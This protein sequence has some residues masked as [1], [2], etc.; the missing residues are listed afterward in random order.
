MKEILSYKYILPLLI[1]FF[2]L[3]FFSS[4]LISNEIVGFLLFGFV[5]LR[6]VYIS[7][8]QIPIKEIFLLILIIQYFIAP[9]VV[10]NK[11]DND[12]GDFGY[13]M[14]IYKEEYF[15]FIIGTIISVLIGL[16][17]PLSRSKIESSKL[18]NRLASAKDNFK[19]GLILLIIGF[20][21]HLINP[22]LPSSLAFLGLF[23]SNL[24][25]IAA[26]YIYFSNNKKKYIYI[27]IVITYLVLNII[28]GGV[29]IDLFIWG[30]FFATYFIINKKISLLIKFSA[31]LLGVFTA[32]LIQS[33]KADYRKEIW[34]EDRNEEIKEEEMFI[35]LTSTKLQNATTIFDEANTKAFFS[36]LNQGW[37]LSNVLE[38]VPKNQDFSNGDLFIRELQGIILPRIIAPNKITASGKDV[39]DKFIKYT[40][41]ILLGNTTMNIGIIADGYINF[42]TYGCWYFM[43]FIG[44]FLNFYIKTLYKIATNY[45]TIVLWLP[46]LFFYVIRTANDF[47][48]VMNYLVKSSILLAAVVYLFRNKFYKPQLE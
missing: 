9:S 24:K 3:F 20:L 46:V 44:L 11:F 15:Y 12:V 42:G 47:Y 23:L 16:Y 4:N 8:N 37:I 6:L 26:F 48:M 5:L 33:I 43:F 10:Y 18:F 38:H 21:S 40:G 45:P 2:Y 41:R 14:K 1:L 29:F 36:R 17:I 13:E 28:S 25:Y 22:L 31:I 30:L 35:N 27:S 34:V 32:L 7:V 39:K 19:I